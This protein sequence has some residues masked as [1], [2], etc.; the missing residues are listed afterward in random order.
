MNRIVIN[1]LRV[2]L[3]LLALGAVGLQVV[4]VALVVNRI[5]E[6]RAELLPISNSALAFAA[7]ACMEIILV[8]LWTLLSMVQREAIFGESAFRWVDTISIAGLV[9][10][11][12]LA[13]VCGING[14]VDDAPG[15]VLVGGGVAVAGITFALLMIVMRGLLRSATAFRRELDE[16]V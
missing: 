7:V 11:F 5:A 9:G 2:L 6:S 8:S 10:A 16:V 14:E 13:V 3:I 4:F 12:L 1:T 15:L